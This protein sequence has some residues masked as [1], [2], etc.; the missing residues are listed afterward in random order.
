M[1]GNKMYKIFYQNLIGSTSSMSL[2][3][4]MNEVS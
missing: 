1:Q 4:T 2:N 3:A